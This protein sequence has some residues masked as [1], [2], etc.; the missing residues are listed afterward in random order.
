MKRLFSSL[1]SVEVG[2]RE[3]VLEAADIPYEV[4]NVTLS[5]IA[6]P[7]FITPLE[8]WVLRDEDYE[9][10]LRLLQDSCES[11]NGEPAAGGKAE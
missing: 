9:P 11:G 6:G 4:R 10:A 2:L 7:S 5:E 8:L 1:D 3:S